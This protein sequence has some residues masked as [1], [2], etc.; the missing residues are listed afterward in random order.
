MTRR[1][2]IREADANT[3]AVGKLIDKLAEGGRN[4]GSTRSALERRLELDPALAAYVRTY[5]HIPGRV[6]VWTPGAGLGK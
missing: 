5:G 3:K 6:D 1:L 4:E 2:S